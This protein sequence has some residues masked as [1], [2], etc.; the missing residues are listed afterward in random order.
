MKNK[1]SGIKSPLRRM[2]G[3]N[4]MAKWIIE[5]MPEHITYVEVF[6]G[7]AHVLVQKTKGLSKCEVYN[8]CNLRL[9]NLFKVLQEEKMTEEL[10]NR[11]YLTPYHRQ[12]LR[13][14]Y[15]KTKN[16]QKQISHPDIEDAYGLLVEMGQT[17]SGNWDR[18]SFANWSYAKK[19]QNPSN[20]WK[21][22]PS[23]LISLIDRIKQVQ[24]ECLDF[25]KLIPKY[26]SQ[27]TLFYCDPPYVSTENYYASSGFG[28]QEHKDLAEILNGVSG[29]VILSY[30]SCD[31]IND[32]YPKWRT[33][34]KDT[35]KYSARV[36]VGE[37]RSTARELLLMNF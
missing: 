16:Q 26:D 31:L 17:F 10:L 30:Y 1:T 7:A 3:K 12:W 5:Q 18:E 33:E 34:Y 23:R 8:D 32:L 9:Y 4:L 19:V 2:G 36:E 37:K 13:D 27:D 11:L 22:F 24:I 20:S 29:K 6:G 35:T 25:R 15:T 28:L 21:N 14:V